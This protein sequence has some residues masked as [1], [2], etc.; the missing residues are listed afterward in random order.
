M[1]VVYYWIERGHIAAQRRKPGLPYAIT[2]T[3]TTDRALREWV[4]TS[5]HM[6]HRS[7]TQIE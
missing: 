1:H 7:Q 2:I 5:S 6:T 3:D 4:A